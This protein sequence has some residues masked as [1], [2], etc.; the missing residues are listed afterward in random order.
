MPAKKTTAKPTP[1]EQ[2]DE[3]TV[4]AVEDATA[5]KFIDDYDA[6]FYNVQ[7]CTVHQFALEVRKPAAQCRI[8][9]T[10]QAAAGRVKRNGDLEW[11]YT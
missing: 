11:H 10:E 3:A 5:P 2:A 9:L 8:W 6:A 1:S 4:T 7:P